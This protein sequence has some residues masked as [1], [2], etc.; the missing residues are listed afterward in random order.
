MNLYN[1]L[2]ISFINFEI[3]N[4]LFIENNFKAYNETI[5]FSSFMKPNLT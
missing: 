3:Y 4:K 5:D 1:I 2:K